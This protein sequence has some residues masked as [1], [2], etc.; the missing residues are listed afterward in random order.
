[1]LGS[2]MGHRLMCLVGPASWRMTG[3]LLAGTNSIAGKWIMLTGHLLQV[4]VTLQSLVNALGTQST[5]CYPILLR[6]LQYCTDVSQVLPLGAS[7]PAAAAQQQA[8]SRFPAG[9]KVHCMS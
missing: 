8:A 4:L 6:V 5:Q 3:L 2:T 7:L 9:W 1:M